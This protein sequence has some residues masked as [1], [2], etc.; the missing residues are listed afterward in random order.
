MDTR[1][2]FEAWCEETGHAYAKPIA[3]AFSIWQAAER[4][5]NARVKELEANQKVIAFDRDTYKTHMERAIALAEVRG[6]ALE[7]VIRISDR[8]HDA[9]DRAKAALSLSRPAA[10]DQV[11][12]EERERSAKV[13]DELAQNA[14]GDITQTA[15]IRAA[16][17]IRALG[18][19]G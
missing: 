14:G 8:K 4:A 16:Y 9:W 2:R 12:A 6:K 5:A 18:G 13:C 15:Y 7:E 17:G 19:K 10:L 1:E 11:R 3:E